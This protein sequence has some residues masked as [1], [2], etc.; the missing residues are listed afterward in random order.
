MSVRVAVI[1]AGVMGADHARL[2]AE[3]VPGATLQVICDQNGD[4]A[5]Q[6]ADTCGAADIG[7]DGMAV[8]RRDDVDAVIIASPDPTHMPLSKL[9]IEL[10]K[11]ALCEKPLSQSSAECIE[12][13]QAEMAAGRRWVQVGFMR[14][15]DQPYAEMRDAIGAAALGRI[16]MMHN[17]HRNVATPYAAFTGAMAITNSAPHEFDIVR[18]VL[19]TEF[20]R[21]SAWQPKRT[22]D[23]VAPV[24]MV[25]ET[26]DD[27]LVTV[28]VNNNAAYGYDVR[29]ELIGE[30]GSMTMSPPVHTR[31][32]RDFT[33]ASRYHPDWRAPYEDAY[34]RQNIDFI[35]FAAGGPFPAPAASC[36]DGYC[37]SR[38]AEAGVE[39]LA[40]GDGVMIDMI[41]Q[42]D[43]YG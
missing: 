12:V 15:Y 36:W 29:A 43:F 3:A 10:G 26:A 42:P 7:A 18:H 22:D 17:F 38:I 16:L 34:R 41:D 35:R 9:C 40:S 33:S 25:L 14:R 2:L 23:V 13:M 6:V 32:D 1:G 20:T 31:L 5:R 30:S 28:E 4:T 37:A 39:A 8:V 27:Q 24:V 21:I 19:G 11:P